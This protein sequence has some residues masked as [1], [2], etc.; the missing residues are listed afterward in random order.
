MN[1]KTVKKTQGAIVAQ[2][3]MVK[4]AILKAPPR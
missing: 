3:Q 2:Q 1:G 4:N